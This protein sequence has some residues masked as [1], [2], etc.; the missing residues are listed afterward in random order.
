MLIDRKEREEEAYGEGAEENAGRTEE[1][2]ASE[3]REEHHERMELHASSHEPRP[4]KVVNEADRKHAPYQ[5]P[6]RRGRR[7]GKE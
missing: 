5:E 4:E 3:Y 6:Y 1:R 2:E 7:S